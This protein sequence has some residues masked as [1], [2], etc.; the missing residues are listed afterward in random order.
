MSKRLWPQRCAAPHRRQLPQKNPYQVST[1]T[2]HTGKSVST[3]TLHV[4]S[5]SPNLGRTL[6]LPEL[7]F[8]CL[9]LLV[10][11]RPFSP[12]ISANTFHRSAHYWPCFSSDS[13]RPYYYYCYCYYYDSTPHHKT[14]RTVFQ[15]EKKNQPNERASL[16]RVCALF[17]H[18]GFFSLSLPGHTLALTRSHT[19]RH[20]HHLAGYSAS[21]YLQDKEERQGS[22]VSCCHRH[23]TGILCQA[24]LTAAFFFCPTLA[25]PPSLR[26]WRA[27]AASC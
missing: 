13:S 21:L 17:G 11:S 24:S 3:P 19:A 22:P 23:L 9:T 25:R 4:F 20:T 5:R 27:S 16:R 12:Y 7:S 8:S 15:E 26:K 14:S 10:K 18:S 1:T 6:A 2:T